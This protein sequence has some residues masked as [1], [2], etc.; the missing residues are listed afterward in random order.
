MVVQ[1]DQGADPES[2]GS[3]HIRGKPRLD[4]NPLTQEDPR[5]R[6][7]PFVLMYITQNHQGSFEGVFNCL[8]AFHYCSIGGSMIGGSKLDFYVKCLHYILIQVGCKCIA[9]V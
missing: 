4:L 9:V 5:E 8:V 1:G 7:H 2:G 6:S 3:S